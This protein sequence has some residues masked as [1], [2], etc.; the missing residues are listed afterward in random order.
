MQRRNR[1]FKV[2]PGSVY[3]ERCKKVSGDKRRGV[4]LVINASALT[5]MEPTG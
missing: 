5:H 4:V 2:K 3:K 1:K